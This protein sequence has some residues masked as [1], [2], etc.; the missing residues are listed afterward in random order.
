MYHIFFTAEAVAPD[1]TLGRP[2]FSVDPVIGSS[3]GRGRY[4]PAW[5]PT[6]TGLTM[7]RISPCTS[8]LVGFP[9]GS[10]EFECRK[11]R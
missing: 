7:E 10:G 5:Y 9:F 2:R 4:G 1:L 11:P 3:Y 8:D 6:R